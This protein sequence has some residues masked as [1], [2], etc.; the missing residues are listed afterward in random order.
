MG[1]FISIIRRVFGLLLA[2]D[3]CHRCVV[4]Q[5]AYSDP[6]EFHWCISQD[7]KDQVSKCYVGRAFYICP[8]NDTDT[9]VRFGETLPQAPNILQVT[10]FETASRHLRHVSDYASYKKLHSTLPAA[11]LSALKARVRAGK[12]E[13]I[14]FV[15]DKK[16][17][18]FLSIDFE[19]NERNEKSVLEWG[20]A[21]V[22]CGHLEA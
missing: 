7:D 15:W 16:D 13:A 8:I 2:S 12:P 3:H 4:G 14:K 10:P 22:R 5:G 9:L 19:W 11:I 21:A 17:K 6:F 1:S 18:T 20:Y